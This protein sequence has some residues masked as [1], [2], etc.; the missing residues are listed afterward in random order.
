MVGMF[1]L[2]CP[3]C[4]TWSHFFKPTWRQPLVGILSRNSL[5]GDATERPQP[6]RLQMVARPQ[7]LHEEHPLNL[8][9]AEIFRHLAMAPL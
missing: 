7:T 3:K 6:P 9:W 4:V 5:A 2:Y 8:R 1:F